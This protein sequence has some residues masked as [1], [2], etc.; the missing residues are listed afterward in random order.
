MTTRL[1]FG[2]LCLLPLL[3]L[4]AK[5]QESRRREPAAKPQKAPAPEPAKPLDLSLIPAR[6]APP[7]KQ[8]AGTKCELC[9]KPTGWQEASFPHDRT[10]FPLRGAH[11]K[12]ECKACHTQDFNQP[13][14]SA[15]ASCHRDAHAGELGQRCEGCHDSK[16]WTALFTA[17]AHRRTNFPLSGRHAILPCQ[18]CH[19][20]MRGPQFGRR[21]VECIGCHQRDYDRTALTTLDHVALGL[22]T[23]CRQCH[24][25]WSFSHARFPGHDRCFEITGGEH[26]GIACLRCHSSLSN[27][28][29]TGECN[30]QTAACTG[31]HEHSCSRTDREHREV[32][33]YQC[34]DRKCYEC[35]RFSVEP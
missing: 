9:H 15:C 30:T 21:T 27:V 33:G 31:C 34:K 8:H 1:S 11:A 16:G 6:L 23:D 28:T 3:L 5:P 13:L 14:A 10:G 29:F 35:H 25:P 12:T 18:E 2:L 4:G 19:V 24:Q 32:P 20:D 22:P 17:D 7:K 26:A